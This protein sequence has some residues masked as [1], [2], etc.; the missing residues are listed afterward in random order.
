MKISEN[1]DVRLGDKVLYREKI[2]RVTLNRFNGTF[3]LARGLSR[4]DHDIPYKR[5]YADR[6]THVD[7]LS[8]TK[9][10]GTNNGQSRFARKF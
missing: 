6:K 2:W 7:R 8:L 9:I 1:Q 3:D 4:I 10:E 5:G